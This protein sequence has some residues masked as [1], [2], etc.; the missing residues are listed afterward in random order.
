MTRP[1]IFFPAGGSALDTAEA[2]FY[3]LTAAPDGLSVDGTVIHPGL[4]QRP[5]GLREL[6]VLLAHP[7]TSAAARHAVWAYLVGRREE[8]AWQ[9]G[10]VGIAMP[11]LRRTAGRLAAGYP[12]DPAD[13]DAEVLTGFLVGLRRVS[14]AAPRLG[15]RLAWA[16]YRAGVDEAR[17]HSVALPGG[18]SG[19]PVAAAMPPA[20]WGAPRGVLAQAVAAGVLSAADAA[21]IEVS[22][23]D[24][25]PLAELS[26]VSGPGEELAVRLGRAETRL[27]Q[28]IVTGRVGVR[29][30]C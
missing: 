7:A 26:T 11:V 12:G 9:V 21:L 6:R 29:L 19:L 1:D 14:P 10:A 15:V 13:L 20:P 16:A 23:L 5:I 17:R 28:A 18:G 27:A 25:V 24:G 8:P 4:P 22:R 2:A 30:P 3:T